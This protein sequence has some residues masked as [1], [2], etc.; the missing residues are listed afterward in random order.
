MPGAGQV[1]GRALANTSRAIRRVLARRALP[2]KKSCWVE[3]RLQAHLRDQRV[4]RTPFVSEHHLTFLEVLEVIDSAG[5]DPRVDGLL[6]KFEGGPM[7][8]SQ[9]LSLRRATRHQRNLY[10]M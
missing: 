6:L 3:V 5:R 2:R 7:S 1:A 10:P 9:A 8:F 4:P